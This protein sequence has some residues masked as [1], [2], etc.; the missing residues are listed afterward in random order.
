ML[1]ARGLDPTAVALYQ[2]NDRPSKNPAFVEPVP[3]DHLFYARPSGGS[4]AVE[5]TD[6][7]G[8]TFSSKIPV[9]ADVNPRRPGDALGFAL[10]QSVVAFRAASSSG[11]APASPCSQIFRSW[12]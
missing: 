8:R 7:F 11:R 3:T 4:V 12:T 9:P 2:G 1:R 6:R 5:V 10:A